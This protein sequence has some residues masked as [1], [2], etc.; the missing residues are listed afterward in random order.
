MKRIAL[1]VFLLLNCISFGQNQKITAIP[2]ETI[3]LQADTFIGVD[4]L[5]YLYYIKDNVFFKQKDTQ[6]WEYKNM[7]LGKITAVDIRNPLSFVVFY[8]NFN[9]IIM[10]DNQ[11]NEIQKINFNDHPFPLNIT[12]AGIASQNQLWVYDSLNQQI[13]LYNYLNSNYKPVSIPLSENIL[14]YQ[15]EFNSFHWIDKKNKWYSVDLY[16]KI[17]SRG[18]IPDFDSITIISDTQYILNKNN[19]LTFEDT[20][21]KLK[22]EIKILEKTFKK[23]CY[24]DR[25]LT[26]FT[27]EGIT[28]YKITIP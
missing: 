26:I 7:G 13:G 16:G 24:K 27:L 15:S 19:V 14:C 5:G 3:P 18:E 1:F 20:A 21:K 23:L 11:L 28:N 12:A 2:L 8:E 4:G 17:T 9:T 22:F 6:I 10:L 25:I